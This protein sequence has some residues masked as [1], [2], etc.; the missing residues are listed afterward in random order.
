MWTSVEGVADPLWPTRS[1]CGR[2]A[3]SP[4]DSTRIQTEF[5]REFEWLDTGPVIDLA[6]TALG[7]R[8][9]RPLEHVRLP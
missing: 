8:L 3:G 9:G 7:L 4:A 2:S 5:G 1:R 6:G